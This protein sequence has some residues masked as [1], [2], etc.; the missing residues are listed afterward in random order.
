VYVAWI[1]RPEEYWYVGKATTVE[2]LNLAAH[3]KLARATAHA[4]KLSLIFP[5]Q[6]RPEV[7]GGVEG[8]LLAMIEH[9]SSALPKLNEKRES[10]VAHQGTDE[11]M[12]LSSFL[13]DIAKRI[14]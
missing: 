7:L 8:S 12:T 14:N 5:S 10:V 2:R 1:H 6:S 3:G 4:T 11:L 9:H 13:R